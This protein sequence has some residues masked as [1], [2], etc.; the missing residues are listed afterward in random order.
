MSTRRAGRNV[1]CAALVSLA[2]LQFAG[3]A[4]AHLNAKPYARK[5]DWTIEIIPDRNGRPSFCRAKRPYA[6]ETWLAFSQGKG[7]FAIEFSG[8]GSLAAGNKYAVQF[9]IDR[10]RPE[11]PTSTF[12]AKVEDPD[13]WELMR[14]TE[15]IDEIGD[16][17]LLMNGKVLHIR[18]ASEKWQYD[19]R[20]ANAALNS[21]F[22]CKDRVILN[23][24]A[25]RMTQAAPQ[26]PAP[27]AAPPPGLKDLGNSVGAA[28]ADKLGCP[29]PGTIRSARSNDPATVTFINNSG[30]ALKISWI[31]FEGAFKNYRTLRPG[32]RYTQQTFMGHPWVA[33]EVGNDRCFGSVYYPRSRNNNHTFNP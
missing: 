11:G 13:D 15:G 2:G 18:S 33:Q 27:Q 25:P 30:R 9:W 1:L 14:V 17:D 21:L 3:D 28:I 4:F 5:G 19:L 6:T 32:E 23:Q 29:R 31:D 7:P 8:I 26:R 24:N 16:I 22:E 10:P 12:A 20:G